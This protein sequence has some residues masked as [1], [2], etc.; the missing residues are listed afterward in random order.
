MVSVVCVCVT[1]TNPTDFPSQVIRK[2]SN[3][4]RPV[5]FAMPQKIKTPGKLSYRDKTQPARGL[6]KNKSE[7]LLLV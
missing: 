2:F 7:E 4:E 5:F 1:P 6:R 3:K